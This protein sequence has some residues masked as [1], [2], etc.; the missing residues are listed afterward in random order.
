MLK[1]IFF[2]RKII[3]LALIFGLMAGYFRFAP[4]GAVTEAELRSKAEQLQQQI[5]DNEDYLAGVEDRAQTLEN[6][7][8][9]IQTEINNAGKK[10][11]LA[12]L[13]IAELKLELE[14]TTA[15]LERQKGI[16]QESL[17]TLYIEGDLSTFEL[18][19]SAENFGEFFNEQEYLEQLKVAVQDSADK[20]AALKVKI[21][22]EKLREEKLLAELQQQKKV[23]SDRRTEQSELLERTRGEEAAYKKVLNNLQEDLQEAQRELEAFL[24]AQNFQ[25]LGYVT[26]GTTIGFVG[27]TGFSTG[28]HLH[29]AIYDN[30]TFVNPYAGGMTYGMQWPLPT[31]SQGSISQVFGCV[32]PYSWYITKCSNGNSL[33]TG[34]DVSAWYGEPIVAAGDGDIVY[35]GYLGGYGNAVIIDHGG[36]VQT[37]YAHMLD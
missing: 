2:S 36:G 33:H 37:Y 23:L 34:L 20:V 10:I 24:A 19:L 1:Q 11:E 35:R 29:F 25:S 15:E 22:S 18:L 26:A 7:L 30:G 16:V 12:E 32:A 27:S 5:E 4:V 21:E 13:K 28:P 14:K 3:V 17:R 8:Y 9:A 31:V 6:R